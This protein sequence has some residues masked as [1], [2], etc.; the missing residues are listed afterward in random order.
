MN[1]DL[2]GPE[3]VRRRMAELQA[4]LDRLNPPREDAV[5]SFANLMDGAPLTGP[6]GGGLE[7]F[8]VAAPGVAVQA[9][10]A[11]RAA[12]PGLGLQ[13]AA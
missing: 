10:P 11:L 3:G 9:E 2:L 8:P 12:A 1:I 5:P 13:G 7:P 4:R 6:I